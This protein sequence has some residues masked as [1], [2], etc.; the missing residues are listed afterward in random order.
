MTQPAG[1]QARPDLESQCVSAIK[2]L[3]VDAVEKAKSGHPGTPM[4]AA[5]LAF[6]LWSEYLRFDPSDPG[7]AGRD[8]FVLSCG[9]AC[10]LQYS[11]LHLFG[12]ALPIEELQRFRQ[13]ESLTPGHPERETA[14]VEIATGPLGQGTGNAVGMAIAA[15]MMAARYHRPGH[16]PFAQ[17]VY[18]IVSDGDLMEGIS[19]EAISMAGHLGLS[20]LTYLYDDNKITIEGS[21]ELAWSEDIGK[22]FE[23]CGWHVQRIDGHDRAAIR[24]ALDAARAVEDR[25]QVIICRTHIAN[26]AP[27]KKDSHKAHG[28][29]LGPDETAATKRA[30]GWP[31][32]PAFF[33]PDEVRAF[34]ASRTAA[35]RAERAAWEGGYKAWR[36]A[37]P[38]LAANYDA[39]STRAVPADLEAQLLAAAPAKAEAT[40]NLSNAILQKAAELVPALVGG[41]ADLEPSTKTRVSAS[42]SIQRG[43]FD[44]RNFHFGIREHAM[45]AVMNGMAA[46][47]GWIPYG[48]TF[49]T[50]SDYMRP[51]VRLA[52]LMHLPAIYVWTHDSIFVGEDGPTHQPIEHVASLRLIP[53]LVTFRPADGVETALAWAAALRRQHGP[54]ALVL[55]RQK[56]PLLPRS[57]PLDAA[58]FAKGGYVV[59]E[60]SG[61]TPRVVIAA[62]GSEVGTAMEAKGKLEAK[63]IATRVVSVPSLETFD[64][65]PQS[66][67]DSVLT[68]S[69]RHVAV[70]AGVP[71]PWYRHVGRDGLVLGIRRFGAS[72]PAEVLAEK[73]GFTG[74]AV[75]ERVEQSLR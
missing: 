12:F 51:S 17:R 70:E 55:T 15:K 23:A 42:G 75:A 32:Q 9:H 56:T 18:A 5:D 2:L 69:A 13:W 47:G 33:V 31:E 43:K 22:R 46:Y 44:G 20:N 7:W 67:R 1:T 14:G 65:Q 24:K 39:V 10:M 35:K 50:F 41:S 38:D 37:H 72:A 59:S 66:W 19:A 36:A 74:A 21:T 27:N 57:A 4:G 49:L 58:A 48:S 73:F 34:F 29:P 11:L 3:A 16:T 63:G 52:A 28:E 61:G 60:A 26:G 25:P 71:D 62:S 6:V 40:R 30:L 64:Q 68:P 45:G 54:T 53:N 8:R